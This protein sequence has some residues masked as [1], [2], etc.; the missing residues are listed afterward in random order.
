[1]ASPV[2][3][4]VAHR[5]LL[6]PSI[7]IDPYF[8]IF[9][10]VIS[11]YHECCVLVLQVVGRF[12]LLKVFLHAHVLQGLRGLQSGY[13]RVVRCLG[14]CNLE[15][16]RSTKQYLGQNIRKPFSSENRQV[17]CI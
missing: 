6:S 16:N 12:L 4:S 9:R 5:C 15:I 1:M 2:T 17:V 3:T 14:L 10:L 13:G 8:Y 11:H 7:E